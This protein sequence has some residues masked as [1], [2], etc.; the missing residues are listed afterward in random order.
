MKYYFEL[1][2][3]CYLQKISVANNHYKGA[4]S[5]RNIEIYYELFNKN[6][7]YILNRKINDK[8]VVNFRKMRSTMSFTEH[9]LR[10]RLQRNGIQKQLKTVILIQ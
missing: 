7:K 9:S 5:A 3:I 4:F 10:E 6:D 8:R 2:I 1:K